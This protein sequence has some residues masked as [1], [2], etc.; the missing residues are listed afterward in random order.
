MIEERFKMRPD[1][2]HRAIWILEAQ[3]PYLRRYEVPKTVP[4]NDTARADVHKKSCRECRL[5]EEPVSLLKGSEVTE[6]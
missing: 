1:R 2:G 5:L 3:L 4:R 6:Q